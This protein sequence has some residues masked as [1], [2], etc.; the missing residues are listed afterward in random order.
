MIDSL[1]QLRHHLLGPLFFPRYL[2]DINNR[3]EYPLTT[4]RVDDIYRDAKPFQL[5]HRLLSVPVGGP[6]HQIGIQR[7]DPFERDVDKGTHPWFRPGSL[8]V[9]TE[10]GHPYNFPI[11]VEG[12]EG[13]GN[14]GSKRD[15]P[16]RMR[17][18]IDTSLHIVDVQ[19]GIS[20]L[21]KR[22]DDQKKYRNAYP[23]ARFQYNLP[24]VNP[25]QAAGR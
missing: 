6:D 5:R 10:R 13:L 12:E 25:L 8:R 21:Q 22:K 9:V 15:D 23:D 3:M 24:G 7:N 14:A 16:L 20:R 2:S 18:N 4:F 1:P 17:G 11:Q 19:L